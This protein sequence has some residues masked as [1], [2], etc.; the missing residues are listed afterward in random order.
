MSN[1][2]YTLRDIPEDVWHRVKIRAQIERRS[3]KSLILDLLKSYADDEVV[4][5]AYWLHRHEESLAEPGKDVPLAKLLE[6]NHMKP[7]KRR[8]A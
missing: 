5:D 3:L 1:S 7:A 4:E 2:S 6:A 8:R